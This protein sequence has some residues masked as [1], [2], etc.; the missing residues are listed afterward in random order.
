VYFWKAMA[1]RHDAILDYFGLERPNHLDWPIL[2]GYAHALQTSCALADAALDIPLDAS[3][4]ADF[5]DQG[6][7]DTAG[8]AKF[9]AL[10]APIADR[11]GQ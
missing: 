3:V 2:G 7:F 8:A 5:V 11:A 6:H 9:A 4:A 10:V 1:M